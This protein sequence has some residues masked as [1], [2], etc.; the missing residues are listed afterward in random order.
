MK[1]AHIHVS[2]IVQGVYFR[3]NTLIKAQ[4]LGLK[5][6]VRNLRD[7]RVEVI[8]EGSG[9]AIDNLIAWC[10]R[11]PRGSRV[12]DVDT[13]WEELKGEFDDFRIAY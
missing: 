6:L 10:R 4:E 1:R 9:E 2:G 13:Q 3:Q 7:G 5:G 12:E 8:C 11:G